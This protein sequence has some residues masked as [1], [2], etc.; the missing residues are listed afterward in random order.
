VVTRSDKLSSAEMIVSIASSPRKKI[1]R[2]LYYAND[3]SLTAG[4]SFT[5]EKW[6]S[7]IAERYIA[8]LWFNWGNKY[9][10]LYDF[11]R[12]DFLLAAKHRLNT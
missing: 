12:V 1:C 11:K 7:D 3:F 8:D 4:N 6:N 10:T 2:T 5:H 9:K